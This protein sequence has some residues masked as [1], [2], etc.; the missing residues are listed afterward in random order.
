MLE[1]GLEPA[2]REP[3]AG[4]VAEQGSVRGDG[5]AGPQL[6]PPEPLQLRQ[7][8]IREE[9]IADA[10]ALGDLTAQADPGSRPAIGE[11]DIPDVQ[12]DDFRQ[13]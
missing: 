6:V 7:E 11:V 12:P 2:L 8:G 9:D 10:A 3:L 4:L 13:P 5:L 1:D